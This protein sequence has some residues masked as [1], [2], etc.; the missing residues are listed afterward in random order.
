MFE[1]N[2]HV[3]YDVLSCS[4]DYGGRQTSQINQIH[5]RSTTFH[6]PSMIFLYSVFTSFC[7]KLYR[8]DASQAGINRTMPDNPYH[9]VFDTTYD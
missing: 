2:N 5:T 8:N 4:N 9:D 7:D 1:P 6:F 3:S